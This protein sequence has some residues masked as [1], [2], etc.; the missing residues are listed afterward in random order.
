M[1]V[2][3]P[4]IDIQ[5]AVRLVELVYG[6]KVDPASVKEFDGYDDRNFYV[7]ADPG[8]PMPDDVCCEDG[9][10]LKVTNT[11]DSRQP[12][13]YE[14]QNAAM[15]HLFERGIRCQR[16]VKNKEGNL[17]KLVKMSTDMKDSKQDDDEPCVVRLLTFLPGKTLY[18]LSS[19]TS[20]LF[21]EAGQF[22]AKM[23][24][25]MGDF[26]HPI[27]ATRDHFWFLRNMPQVRQYLHVVQDP[28]LRSICSQVIDAFETEVLTKMSELETGF[29]HG[30][31][32]EQ[33]CL[34]TLHSGKKESNEGCDHSI[35]GVI[36]FGDSYEGPYVF[37]LGGTIMYCMSKSD[38]VDPNL[39]GGHV[40]A[41]YE[42]ER[43]V[44]DLEMHILPVVVAGRW[45]QSLVL[46]A[47]YYSIDPSNEYVL[48][49]AKNGGWEI[50]RT[51]WKFP[52]EK[53][54]RDWKE[55]ARNGIQN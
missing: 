31:Y 14:G 21:H 36:D 53:I 55:I 4:V 13:Q 49:T 47:Y 41:G 17:L 43:H 24:K 54:I 51:F 1:A 46:G 20:K 11:A 23:D 25:C 35:D 48:N 6:F 22:V 3:R 8:Q 34:V 44:P 12:V 39:V 18:E 28:E 52:R 5:G 45:T 50:L 15:V 40:L 37:E 42:T 30:D 19:W 16:P 29:I 7:K 38:L 33:N 32:N 10:V 26:H 9:Y 2:E 27:F